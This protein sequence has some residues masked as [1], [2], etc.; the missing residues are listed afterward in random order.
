MLVVAIIRT[1]T[2]LKQPFTYEAR[3]I[4]TNLL[5]NVG[6]SAHDSN[7]FTPKTTAPFH[8]TQ[9]SVKGSVELVDA[10]FGPFDDGGGGGCGKGR[11]KSSEGVR[12]EGECDVR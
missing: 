10:I 6:L 5:Q 12:D 11:G 3:E 8:G 7:A 2:L 1:R 4:D 9:L